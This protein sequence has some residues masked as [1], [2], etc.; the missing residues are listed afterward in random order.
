L[1]SRLLKK[2]S[3]TALSQQLPRPLRVGATK[4]TVN[5]LWDHIGVLLDTFSPEEC[6]NFM[7]KSK[8]L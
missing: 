3:A 4:R 7:K 1:I 5:A 2:D 8:M 6:R